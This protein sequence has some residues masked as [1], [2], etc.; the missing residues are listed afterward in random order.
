ML[1]SL[2]RDKHKPIA[3]L[4]MIAAIAACSFVELK[5]GAE[6][7][8]IFKGNE[9]CEAI[10]QT[11]VN[12]IV[13]AIGIDRDTATIAEEL[14]TLARNNALQLQANAIWPITQVTDGEQTYRIMRCLF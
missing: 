1:H 2:I 11:E 13:T 7:V 3:V 10:G 5:P 6:N 4:A 12:V 9:R 14:Q 8:I